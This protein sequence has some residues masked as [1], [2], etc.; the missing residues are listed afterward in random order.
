MNASHEP[1]KKAAGCESHL[2]L[3][4]ETLGLLHTW[5]QAA[6]PYEGC[7][8]FLGVQTAYGPRVELA[9]VERNLHQARARDR[10]ELDPSGFI[11]AQAR[12]ETL[13]MD[14]V[15]VWHSHPEHSSAASEIDRAQAWSG[16]SYVILSVI[17]GRVADVR[18][19]RLHG[20]QFI[21]EPI[22]RA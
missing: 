2:L 11:R 3:G 19:W 6:Y 14:I 17:A 10:Y 8:L 18:S 12:A 1:A 13:G 22:C 16:W 20:G 4:Q 15:G 21:E 9:T 7:G 5:A